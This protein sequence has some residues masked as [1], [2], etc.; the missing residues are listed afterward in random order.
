VTRARDAAAKPQDAW[1]KL[2][3]TNACVTELEKNAGAALSRI[4]TSEAHLA[5]ADVAEDPLLEA[6]ADRV[7]ALAERCV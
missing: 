4:Q 7:R 1:R 3:D 2:A 6:E 5:D